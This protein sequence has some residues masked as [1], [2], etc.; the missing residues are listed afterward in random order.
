MLRQRE[1]SVR[2]VITIAFIILLLWGRN[3]YARRG[4][5]ERQNVLVDPDKLTDNRT[6]STTSTVGCD[7][8]PN[9]S[10]N[11]DP[12]LC[13]NTE[14][15]D[16][17]AQYGPY[18]LVIVCNSLSIV[19]TIL[20]LVT[21][22]LFRELRSLPGKI[23]MNL[24]AA[25][26]LTALILL[27]GICVIEY[28]TLCTV[29]A[30][31]AHYATLSQFLWMSILSFEIART[32]HH[33]HHFRML[34][35]K[36]KQR[37]YLITYLCIGW[38]IPLL[39]VTVSIALHFSTNFVG[40]GENNFCFINGDWMYV[41]FILLIGVCILFNIV[42][43]IYIGFLIF[44]A[45]IYQFKLGKTQNVPYVRIM[46]AVVSVTGILYL[47]GTIFVSLTYN[48]SIYLYIISMTSQGFVMCIVMVFTKKIAVLYKVTLK[49]LVGKC[50]I[51]T[52]R[53]ST[54]T[55]ATT[56]DLS[57]PSNLHNTIQPTSTDL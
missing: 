32:L 50:C 2:I 49:S 5:F 8:I 57:T 20:I 34:E 30:V 40:Y 37:I 4:L 54:E 19:G 1:R 7:G 33:A 51:C 9:D 3:V 43:A 48:W 47:L 21:Y 15:S 10:N 31:A 44:K 28:H 6:N 45:F 17:V 25:T 35:S 55:N 14:T 27:P 36:K 29:L 12:A 53:Q 46:L 42:A 26:L 39:I 23:Q 16:S 24:A 41:L 13:N 22:T 11:S 56:L 18:I 38:G 52:N